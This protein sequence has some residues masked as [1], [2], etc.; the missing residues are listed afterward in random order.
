MN[1]LSGAGGEEIPINGSGRGNYRMQKYLY[2]CSLQ[3]LI[4]MKELY[5]GYK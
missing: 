2:R 1:T 5:A 3:D 4:V